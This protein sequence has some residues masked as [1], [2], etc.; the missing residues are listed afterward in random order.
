MCAKVY[1]SFAF[2]STVGGFATTRYTKCM[3]LDK[4]KILIAEDEAV[5]GSLLEKKLQHDGYDVIWKQDGDEALSTALA[6]RPDAV[7]LDIIM[8]GLDGLS[9][10]KRI[11]SDEKWGKNVPIMILS[12]LSE[13]HSIDEALRGGAFEFLVKADWDIDQICDK[14]KQKLI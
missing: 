9:V 1:L 11:R 3:N 14:I 10:L 4:K 2:L 13:P 6:E 7:L 5:L 8:P 12:N